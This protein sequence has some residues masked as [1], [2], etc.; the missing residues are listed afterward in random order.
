[1]LALKNV[2]DRTF[3][4]VMQKINVAI[5]NPWFMSCFMGS[6]LLVATAG[7]LHWS[8]DARR[9]LPWIIAGLVVY[10]LAFFV[11]MGLNVPL[12]NYLMDAGDPA[13]I[14]DIAAVRS[15]FEAGWVR[16]NVIRAV[17]HTVAFGL[18]AWA[19]VVD[20]RSA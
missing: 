9:V 5:I 1:M 16:W 10:V 4:D 13:K 11:T 17:L 8:G 18:V 14:V 3:V 20:G 2:D 7:A 19:L 6:M 12:N 15:H